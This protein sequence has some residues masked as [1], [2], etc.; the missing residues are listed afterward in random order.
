MCAYTSVYNFSTMF[1][2]M[3]I[4]CYSSSHINTCY[5]CLCRYAIA[6]K[7]EDWHDALGSATTPN[8]VS[9]R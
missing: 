9:I 7:E 6:G 4:L 5:H 3:L 8:I 1:V 2:N